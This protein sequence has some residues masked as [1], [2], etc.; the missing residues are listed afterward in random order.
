[1]HSLGWNLSVAFCSIWFK[2]QNP[3]MAYRTQQIPGLMSIAL[4]P[5]LCSGCAGLLS[6]PWTW[7]ACYPTK[8]RFSYPM[9]INKSV[10]CGIS[11]GDRN[12][13]Y[14][15]RLVCREIEGICPKICFCSSGFG[16]K[17]KRLGRT[18]WHAE[19]LGGQVS[20]GGLQAF[21]VRF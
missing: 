2:I 16:A 1:M 11:F 3:A 6:D 5:L 15:V 13:F 19:M 4:S 10:N 12:Q 21:L 20:T 14:S 17:F 9:C 18:G 7:W 8:L